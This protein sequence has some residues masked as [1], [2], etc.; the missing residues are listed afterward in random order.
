[1]SAAGQTEGAD[2]ADL[3]G[4]TLVPLAISGLT[5]DT[6]G[7]RFRVS[8]HP[9]FARILASTGPLR[10]PAD[11]SLPDPYDGLV[12][13]VAGDLHVRLGCPLS[14]GGRPWGLLTLDALDSATFDD[15]DMEALQ[16]FVSLAAAT[17]SVGE[18]IENLAR[19]G[20]AEHLR[21]EDGGNQGRR[22]QRSHGS[23]HGRDRGGQGAGCQRHS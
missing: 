15:L 4:D 1:M 14:I 17:V 20:A 7:R 16:A 22:R 23:G 10:F 3:R 18:R 11:S 13:H 6:L 12:Q 19:A 8:E 21:A 5:G 2:R 9:R